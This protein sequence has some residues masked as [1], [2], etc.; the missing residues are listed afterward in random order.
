MSHFTEDNEMMVR[1]YFYL[2]ESFSPGLKDKNIVEV[3]S[4]RG[5]GASFISQNYPISSYL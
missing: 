5:G 2:Y 1:L 3:V 4:G